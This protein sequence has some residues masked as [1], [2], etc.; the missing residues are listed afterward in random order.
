MRAKRACAASVSE[1]SKIVRRTVEAA[2]WP[3]RHSDGRGG[4]GAGE[5]GYL[6]SVP[7]VPLLQNLLEAESNAEGPCV[8]KTMSCKR[9]SWDTIPHEQMNPL[10]SRQVVMGEKG[11]V[12]RITLKKGVVVPAHSHESEQVS[13]IVSGKLKFVEVGEGG[14][15]RELV[16]GPGEVLLIPSFL[17]HSAEALEDT[18]AIDIFSPARADWLAGDDAY[19]RGGAAEDGG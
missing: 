2:P 19:L 8:W 10:L 1:R 7:W 9:Y 11:T 18:I 16:L 6:P 3:A 14:A 4:V 5:G 17:V 15:T 13:Y 12:A